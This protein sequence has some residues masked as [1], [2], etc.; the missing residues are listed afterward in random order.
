M[1]SI[2]NLRGSPCWLAWCWLSRPRPPVASSS[3]PPCSGRWQER[4]V[5]ASAGVAPPGRGEGEG[6][7]EGE[8]EGEGEGER[9]GERRREEGEGEGEGKGEE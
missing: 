3:G 2:T 9:K 8:G 1:S 7:E 6:R 5:L 4:L